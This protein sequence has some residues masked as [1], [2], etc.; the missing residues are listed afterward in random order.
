MLPKVSI[1]VP[2]YNA[3]EHFCRCLDSLVNQ[4]LR[5]IQIILV[6]DCPTDGSD[7]TAKQYAEKDTRILIVENEQNLHIGFSRNEGLKVATGEYI[8]FSDHDDF[9]PAD[10]FEKLYEKAIQE[11]ADIVVSNYCQNID[12]QI[13]KYLFPNDSNC[14]FKQSVFEYLL[15]GRIT[16]K[17]K[18]SYAN[19]GGIWNQI[20]RRK[21][22]SV[23]QI[24]FD[25]N[26]VVTMEDTLFNLRAHY[27]A[28]TVCF[29]PETFYQ[30]C[31]N[32]TN[33]YSNY[34]YLSADRVV[35]YLE[36]RYTFLKEHA[37][38]VSYAS[39]NAELTL[40]KLYTSFLNEIR[41]KGIYSSLLFIK[42]VRKNSVLQELL[43]IDNQ[44]LKIFPV[45]KRV[46]YHLCTVL[47]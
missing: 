8:G 7:K 40:R 29:L 33:A 41:H 19:I 24:K 47:S 20:Y 17:N 10:M 3:G 45:T 2:V 30:H 6:L 27:F 46:F 39:Q 1:I 34:S 25:D 22:L 23:N 18:E 9:C 26:K 42:R 35:A 43:T 36:L 31:I 37:L 13:N 21:L 28:R 15:N 14:Q 11:N 16:E 5:D 4:T 44:Y 32:T 12:G 38:L